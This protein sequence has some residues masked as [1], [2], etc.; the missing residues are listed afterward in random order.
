VPLEERFGAERPDLG[1]VGVLPEVLVGHRRRP[2]VLAARKEVFHLA[3]GR[4][5]QVERQAEHPE[6]CH[7]RGAPPGE[8]LQRGALAARESGRQLGKQGRE[9]AALSPCVRVRAGRCGLCRRLVVDRIGRL[10]GLIDAEDVEERSRGRHERG[11]LRIGGIDRWPGCDRVLLRER[12]LVDGLLEPRL[13]EEVIPAEP[14]HRPVLE[15]DRVLCQ[16]RPAHERAVPAAQ[17]LDERRD[18]LDED[19]RVAA[20]DVAHLVRIPILVAR[21]RAVGLPDQEW[22]VAHDDRLEAGVAADGR[23]REA[24][25]P[26][27]AARRRRAR[28]ELNPVGERLA[29]AQLVGVAQPGGLLAHRDAVHGRAVAALEVG[30]VG[31]AVLDENPG[32]AARQAGHDTDVVR[33][34]RRLL[35]P[36][37]EEFVRDADLA[38]LRVRDR[39]EHDVE[40]LGGGRPQIGRQGCCG[41]HGRLTCSRS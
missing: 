21:K 28:H 3:L 33:G 9:P 16:P 40:R 35:P 17:V 6:D 12:R 23:E 25:E 5:P 41:G 11:P 22:E 26:L 10:R 13:V 8:P 32:V 19:V 38:Q 2:R 7:D 34:E 29:E 15:R 37:G 27:D 1:A 14:H 18:A 24:E 20:R 39:P 31:G 30:D 36:D 4:A